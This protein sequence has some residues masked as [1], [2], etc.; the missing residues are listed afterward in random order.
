MASKKTTMEDTLLA[1]LA[2]TTTLAEAMDELERICDLAR[3]NP[4]NQRLQHIRAVLLYGVRHTAEAL[5]TDKD[6]INVLATDLWQH[7]ISFVGRVSEVATLAT[8]CRTWNGLCGS[9]MERKCRHGMILLVRHCQLSASGSV[10]PHHNF[11]G[12]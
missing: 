3:A 8:V 10:P 9:E 4:G 6:E 11:V 1:D 7:I 2:V 5:L 12:I